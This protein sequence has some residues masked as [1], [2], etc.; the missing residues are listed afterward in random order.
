LLHHIEIYVS[1]LA[2]S[3]EFWNWLLTELGYAPYQKRE[4]GIR[5][6]YGHTYIV[7]VQVKERHRCRV[8]L[9]SGFSCQIERAGG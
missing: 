8:G 5:W 9:E 2:K 1:D 4:S 7:F 6:K 3:A